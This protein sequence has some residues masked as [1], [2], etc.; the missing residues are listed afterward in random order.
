MTLAKSIDQP[1]RQRVDRPC[2]ADGCMATAHRYTTLR[3]SV[4]AA[5]HFELKP[6]T[7]TDSTSSTTSSSSRSGGGGGDAIKDALT[8]AS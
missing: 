6:P 2:V 1:T 3:Q 4:I 5:T 7:L 8:C